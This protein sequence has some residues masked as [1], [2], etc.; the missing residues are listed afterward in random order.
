M[1]KMNQSCF[2]FWF[3]LNIHNTR[4]PHLIIS[5]PWYPQDPSILSQMA[6]FLPIFLW[7]SSI[8]LYHVPH[9]LYPSIYQRTLQ[10]FPSL[11]CLD[12]GPPRTGRFFCPHSLLRAISM[13]TLCSFYYSSVTL[14]Y[15]ERRVIRG[16]I[17]IKFFYHLLHRK[18]F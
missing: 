13:K 16:F 12:K 6:A 18:E 8:P 17:V 10:L 2:E 1:M 15:R 4:N 11:G 5:N 7:L 14:I 3:Y 9:L